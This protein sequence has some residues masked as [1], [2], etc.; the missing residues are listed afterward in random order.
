MVVY[1]STFE[2]TTDDRAAFD[3][4]FG[5][6]VQECRSEDGCVFYEYSVSPER[7]SRGVLFGAFET[8]AQLEAHRVYPAHVEIVA[9]GAERGMSDVTVDRWVDGEHAYIHYAHMDEQ[10]TGELLERV[11]ERRLAAA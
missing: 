1:Y 4:W 10:C 8:M 6:L 11:R 9:F 3:E 7:P 2:V 5:G